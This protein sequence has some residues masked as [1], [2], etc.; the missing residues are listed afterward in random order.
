MTA[1]LNNTNEVMKTLSIIAT[2]ALPLI[3]IYE[4]NG[5][6]LL[7]FLLVITNVYII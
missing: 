5:T 2:I 1:I 6:N 7:I 3:V 4:I